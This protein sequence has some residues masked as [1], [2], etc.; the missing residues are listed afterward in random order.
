MRAS[1][2]LVDVYCLSLS[3]ARRVVRGV[4]AWGHFGKTGAAVRIPAAMHRQ[5]LA[6]NPY[7]DIEAT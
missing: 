2:Y 3:P 1:L 4:Q 6:G 5:S 7:Y